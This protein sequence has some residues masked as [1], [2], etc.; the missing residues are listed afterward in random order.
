MNRSDY[1]VGKSGRWKFTENDVMQIHKPPYTMRAIKWAHKEN[2]FWTSDVW[3]EKRLVKPSQ[4]SYKDFTEA[5]RI[6]EEIKEQ[7]EQV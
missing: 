3:V 2:P 4:F 7:D 6:C 5:I 1:I